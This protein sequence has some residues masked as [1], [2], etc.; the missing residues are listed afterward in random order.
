MTPIMEPDFDWGDVQASTPIHKKGEYELTITGVRGSAWFKR[1]KAGNPTTDIT[2][3]VKLRPRIVGV[4]NSEGK[5]LTEQDGKVIK[6]LQCEEINLWVHTEGGRTMSKRQMMAVCGYN[7][8]DEADEKK[9]NEFLKSSKLNL[10]SKVAENES[11]EGLVLAI[12]DG[13][14]TL[15]VGKNVRVNMEPEVR[16]QEGRDDVTQQNYTRLSSVN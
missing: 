5:L 3:V 15:L 6:D 16:K 8:F 11:G 1:D 7:P 2:K 13:W 10:S 12:G 14:K 4:Y 9:F